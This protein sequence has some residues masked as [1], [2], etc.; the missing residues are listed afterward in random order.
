MFALSAMQLDMGSL[1]GNT[2]ISHLVGGE[3]PMTYSIAGRCAR[4]GMLGTIITTSSMAVGNRCH[5]IKAGVGAVLTQHRTDPRLGPLGLEFLQL[6]LTPEET[7]KALVSST[8]HHGWRQLAV[9]DAKGRS[10]HYSGG[11]IRSIHAGVSGKDCVAIGN[12]IR[13]TEVPAAMVRAFEAEPARPIG[14]RLCAALK[15]GHDAGGEF[16][17]VTS[18]GLLAFAK[19]PFPYVDLR[20]DDHPD[21][22]AEIARLWKQWAPDAD[23]YV[24]RVYEPDSPEANALSVGYLTA[25][26]AKA[27]LAKEK[28]GR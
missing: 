20:I 8:R 14:D 25:E 28:T 24:K 17:Q 4:T 21:P 13:S 3:S 18:A 10:A 12:V 23:N 2:E 11:K 27:V 7:I 1:A 22:I 15:A 19:H 16:K 6:G 9:L 26:E 5:F